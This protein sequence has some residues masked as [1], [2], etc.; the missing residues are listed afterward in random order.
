MVRFSFQLASIDG[1]VALKA[2]MDSTFQLRD[3]E[4]RFNRN[5]VHCYD[6]S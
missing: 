2:V 6:S 1:V 4:F 5:F 3:S